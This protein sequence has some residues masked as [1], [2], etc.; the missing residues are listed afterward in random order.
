M[1]EILLPVTQASA[2]AVGHETPTRENNARVDKSHVA[3]LLFFTFGS[4]RSVAGPG[5]ELVRAAEQEQA[6]RAEPRHADLLEARS[7]AA[8]STREA[9]T[10]PHPPAP[11]IGAAAGPQVWNLRRQNKNGD[12]A[13]RTIQPKERLFGLGAAAF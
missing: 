7:E 13:L 5:R 12:W 2:A 4:C 1:S 8:T 6:Q 10:W 3:F 11:G 9:Q